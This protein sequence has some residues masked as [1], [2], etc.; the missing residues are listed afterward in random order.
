MTLNLGDVKG[1][2]KK[3]ED[4]KGAG[5]DT[6][7]K[8]ANATV[9]ELL[10]IKGIG[11][12]SAQ[13]YIDNAKE[14]LEK[15]SE[16]E[17][18]GEEGPV[19]EEDEEEEKIQE[20]L[21]KLE[22]KKKKL[23]GKE[24]KEGDFI[25]VK[26]TAKTQKGKVFQVSSVEDAKIAGIYDEKKEQQGFYAPE[27]VIVGKPGFLN[28][29][30]TDTIKELNYFQK[31]SVRIPPTKAFGKR[32]PQKIERIGIAK[33]RKLNNG[34]NPELGQEFVKQTQQG[35]SQRGT[36]I[37]VTQGKVVVDYNHP[38][39]GQSIDYNLEIIDKI[40]DFNEKIEY[41][42]TSKGIPQ[43]SVADFKANYNKGDNSIEFTIP[44]MFMFQNL[45]YFKFGLAMDIQTHM[46]IGDVKFVELFE[47]MPIPTDTSESVM[48]K[49]E[50]L[51]KQ[52]EEEKSK[53]E[54]E[55]D[56]SKEE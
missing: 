16:K 39:A 46:G 26:I 37:R 31:K 52:N 10:E 35:Q 33:F 2:G 50:E 20:E 13:K 6:V 29:G 12:A 25:L 48:K 11:K 32:D 51:N 24:V 56:T 1:L 45:T 47:K 28:E 54:E 55:K 34:K 30:L 38:L 9:E 15:Q 8:L 44:K 19:K 21:K 4:L 7:D 53:E 23:E 27:F 22:E 40:E 43:Q 14:L 5:I 49:V 17:V 42:M 3:I 36:V 41:F 18:P